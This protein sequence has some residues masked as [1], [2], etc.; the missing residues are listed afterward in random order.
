MGS[1]PGQPA[2]QFF[3]KGAGVG[4]AKAVEQN[5]DKWFKLQKKQAPE[6]K[7]A[8]V[9]AANAQAAADALAGVTAVGSTT[10]VAALDT[11]AGGWGSAPS[12]GVTADN[13]APP[14]TTDPGAAASMSAS[15]AAETLAAERA[16]VRA[17]AEVAAS[18]ESEVAAFTSSVVGGDGGAKLLAICGSERLLYL[19]RLRCWMQGSLVVWRRNRTCWYWAPTTTRAS[20]CV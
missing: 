8:A 2:G 14:E 15:A 4:K 18:L 3:K 12:A 20:S 17:N 9:H 16:A 5:M 11:G 19:T 1:R 7:R 10:S 6:A 13:T